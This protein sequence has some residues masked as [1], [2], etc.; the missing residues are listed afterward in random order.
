MAA[1]IVGKQLEMLK[2]TTAKLSRVAKF[3][4]RSS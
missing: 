3:S 2:Q 1:E 4:K